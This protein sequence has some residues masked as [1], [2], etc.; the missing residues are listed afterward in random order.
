[1]NMYKWVDDIIANPVKKAMPVLSFPAVQ[2]LGIT[3]AELI[4]DSDKQAE[5]LKTCADSAPEAAA[6]V[7]FMDLSLE[8]E[9]FGS[10]IR[11]SD[12]E[13]PTVIGSIVATEEDADALE[14]P[15]VGA[16][17]TKLNIEAI[18]KAKKL[19]TD[20]PVFAGVIGPFSRAG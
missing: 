1:M 7:S 18:E 20:R 5:C 2:K 15:E 14:V 4:N 13:V 9:A 11:V 8:A 3:V 10:T 19:I 16:K 12:D 6:Q 17:R